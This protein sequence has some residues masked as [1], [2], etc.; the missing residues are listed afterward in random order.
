R[1]FTVT[2]T[3]RKPVGRVDSLSVASLPAK[4][5]AFKTCV[6]VSS[7]DGMPVPLK[8]SLRSPAGT[9]LLSSRAEV[10]FGAASEMDVVIEWEGFEATQAGEYKL[11][12]SLDGRPAGE[13][14]LAVQG[15]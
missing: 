11:A 9:E 4:V 2:P 6:R 10:T 8:A 1:D 13:F 5:G 7:G 3:G 12:L 14:P 15:K